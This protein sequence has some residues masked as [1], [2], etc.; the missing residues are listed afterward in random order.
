MRVTWHPCPPK[1]RAAAILIMLL[2]LVFR[3]DT[4]GSIPGGALVLFMIWVM[5]RFGIIFGF[6][7][8]RTSR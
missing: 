4:L 1:V 3:F 7:Q 5:V 6:F 2:I 8:G